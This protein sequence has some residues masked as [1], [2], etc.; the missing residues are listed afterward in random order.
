MRNLFGFLSLAAIVAVA[1][2]AFE[3]G[4]CDHNA[5]RWEYH[6]NGQLLL[7]R[8]FDTSGRPHGQMRRWDASGQLL[9][10]ADFVHGEVTHVVRFDQQGNVESEKREGSDYLMRTLK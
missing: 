2:V 4:G 3:L 1:S 9:E 6:S 10:Q 8:H 7:E 5:V